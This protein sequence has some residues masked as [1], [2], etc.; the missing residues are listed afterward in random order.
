MTTA[1][2]VIVT[3]IVSKL[4]RV[5]GREHHQ[6]HPHPR[7][8]ATQS[9]RDIMCCNCG[10]LGHIY[11]NCNHP[12]TSYGVICFRLHTS[13]DHQGARRV[14]PRYLLV[15]RKDSLSYVEFV[16]GKYGNENRNYIMKLFANM[17]E[18]ERCRIKNEAFDT[19]W[20][21]LWQIDDCTSY[22]KEYRDAKCKFNQ[23]KTGYYL[24]TDLD[25]QLFFNLE[26][27]LDQTTSCVTDTEWG[28]PKG[29][30]NINEND[31][32]CACREFIE[33]TGVSPKHIIAI[34][35]IK[36]FEETFSGSNHV[37]YRHVY[38]LAIH[39]H[40]PP[41]LCINP[42]NRNQIKEIKD[43]QWFTYD[44]AQALVQTENV[45]RK[46][47]FRRAHH[48][49]EKYCCSHDNNQNHRALRVL[50]GRI[51]ERDA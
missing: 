1:S 22:Q 38:Y 31:F 26:Y 3:S 43:L 8:A 14:S 17:T 9:R 15:Q 4:P 2:D 44:E 19:L 28:F 39:I 23:I 37:R 25:P 5:I 40:Q 12:I 46:E 33:E 51:N 34:R 32:A 35:D 48:V 18:I 50:S 30:R 42:R 47:M 20:K 10:N 41:D 45:E 7:S 21:Q 6:H 11:K 29:R 16:R 13:V 49:I 24:K 27:I 36:P